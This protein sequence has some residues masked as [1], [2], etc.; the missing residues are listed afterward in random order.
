MG[1]VAG[2]NPVSGSMA[3]PL[4]TFI[5]FPFITAYLGYLIRTALRFEYPSPF[6]E[7]AFENS[8]EELS[9]CLT[10]GFFVEAPIMWAITATVYFL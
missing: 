5:L 7:P 6:S 4:I 1:E 3:I 9:T 2:S 8:G 10:A